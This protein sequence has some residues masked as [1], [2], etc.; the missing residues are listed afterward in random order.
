MLTDELR[1]SI[2]LQATNARIAQLV[3]RQ[4]SKLR[5]TSSSLVS[6]SNINNGLV[7]QVVR[8]PACHAGGREFESRPDR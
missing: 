1:G 5:V 6:R 8:M 3:E 2:P 7:V 4:P